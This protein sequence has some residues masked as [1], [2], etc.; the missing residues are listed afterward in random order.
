MARRESDPCKPV[1][2]RL[3]ALSAE[4]CRALKL[5]DSGARS[6][7]GNPILVRRM[8]GVVAKAA[9]PVR[10]LLIG[11]IHGDELTS[12]EIVFRWMHMLDQTDGRHFAWSIVPLLNPDGMLA[13]K[14]V[15]MNGNGVDLNRNFPTPHWTSEAPAYW[16]RR[17]G[18]DPRRYPGPAPLSE[19]E[20][21]WLNQEIERFRPDVIVSVH[22]PFGVLDF[23]GPAPAPDRFGRL[24]FT[25][26]G[27]YPGS[28]GNYS[29]VQRNIPV[30]TIELPH[31]LAMPDAREVRRIWDDMLRWITL[32]VQ[33][34]SAR[35]ARS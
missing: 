3:K 12:S 8:P 7:R 10:V 15:R 11:G 18:R 31:A 5:V 25:P 2:A 23:D 13:R 35:T 21:R 9:P 34:Q 14:P 16:I 17:T 33:P 28:L 32:H 1:A 30:I 20:S 24:V 29:G 6:R 22:A 19:P 27:V 26:V 4:D